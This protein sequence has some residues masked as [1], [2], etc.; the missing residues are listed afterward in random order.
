M[1]GAVLNMINTRL[2]AETIAFILEHGEAKALFVDS[3]YAGHF[4]TDAPLHAH[5]FLDKPVPLVHEF[6]DLVRCRDT[7]TAFTPH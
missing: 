7:G 6:H 3:E 5:L 2:D 4:P 1:S